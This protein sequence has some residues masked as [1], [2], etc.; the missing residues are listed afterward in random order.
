MEEVGE[1]AK[2]I[3]TIEIGRDRPDEEVMYYDHARQQLVEELGDI[4][5]NM[6]I[7]SDKYNISLD[8]IMNGHVD[9]LSARFD[10]I[11]KT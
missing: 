8:E 5:T 9:K 1:L 11:I 6:L 10:T 4:L 3:R 2:A 7:L